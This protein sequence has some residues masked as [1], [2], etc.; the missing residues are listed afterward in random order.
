MNTPVTIIG[1]GL[2]GLTLARVLHVHGIAAT[3]YEAEA[4]ANARA[5][6]GNLDIHEYNGQLALKAGG[7]FDKFLGIIQAGGEAQRILGK[8]GNVLLERLDEGNGGRPEV[9]RGDLRRI[10]L[11]SL[12]ADAVHWRHKVTAVS[13]LGGGRHVLT[14]T[15]GST[16][17]TDLL[18][19]AD[20]AWSRVR[21]LVS[22]AKPAYVGT[23]FIETYLFDADTRHKASAEAVGRGTLLAF[24]PGRGIFA[25]RKT[26]GTLHAYAALNKPEEWMTNIDFSDPVATVARVAEEFD[27]WAPELTALITDGETDPAPRPIHALPVGHRWDRVPGVTLLGD[28]AH[29]MS[30]FAGE[31]ANLAMYDGAELGLAVAANPGDV[32]AALTA[33][34]KNLFPRSASAAAESARNLELFFD[35]NT[36]QS[37]VDFFTSNQPVK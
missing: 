22:E 31:G 34:E 24:A 4:S 3:V 17:T 7:L 26:N 23:S 37:V 33:Y 12:P 36:P 19:G 30:P 15:N 35:H 9:D 32:E 21:P 20:G 28:A 2:G 13:P 11:D 25:H 18:V 1:A 10:L 27:G 6:G 5:Q 29:L 8:D 14:F 16:V